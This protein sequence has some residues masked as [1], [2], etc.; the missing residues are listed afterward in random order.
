MASLIVIAVILVLAGILFGGF[1]A[2]SLAISRG[3]QVRSLIWRLH[4]R[5]RRY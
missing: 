4:D 2:I 3:H 1:I 5:N